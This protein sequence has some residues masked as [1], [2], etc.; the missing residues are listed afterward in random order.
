MIQISFSTKFQEQVDVLS[1]IKDRVE[2]DDLAMVDET[3]NFDFLEE[4]LT[5][6]FL[7]DLGFFDDFDGKYHAC[8]LVPT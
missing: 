6:L 3:L 1:I 8:F 4:L 7:L 2:F 5:D